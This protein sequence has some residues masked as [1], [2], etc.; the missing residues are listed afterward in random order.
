MKII[1]VAIL[2]ALCGV[3]VF[4][5]EGSNLG[6]KGTTT[7][8]PRFSKNSCDKCA[9]GM[10]GIPGTHG[11]PGTPGQ[12]GSIGRD[13]PK[14]D[15]GNQGRRGPFGPVGPKGQ[16]GL[17]GKPGEEGKPGFP[18]KTGPRGKPGFPGTPGLKGEI[19]LPGIDTTEIRNWRQCVWNRNDDTDTGKIQECIFM[20]KQQNTAL[21]VIF[22]GNLQVYGANSCR[23]WYFKFNDHE[24][25]SPA[26][27]EAVFRYNLERTFHIQTHRSIEGYCTIPKGVVRVGLWV[28]ACAGSS[29]AG[30]AN[31]GFQS[32]SRIIVEEVPPSQ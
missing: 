7:A 25:S 9:C 29:P 2:V 27:I 21:R 23:R 11:M 14:G 10:P 20:K 31:T 18:G 22:Q 5:D 19:G 30:N 26:P 1:L 24:C 4:C 17:P 15:K 32:V 8:Q 12:P 28:G 13:G 6:A 3:V 16:T